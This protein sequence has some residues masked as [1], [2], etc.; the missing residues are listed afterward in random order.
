MEFKLR[1]HTLED[2]DQI[3]IYANNKGISDNMQDGFPYPYKKEDALGFI[4]MVMKNEPRNI[5]CIE[6]DGKPAGGIG[7]HPGQD[8]FRKN[9][10]LGYWLAEPYWGNGIIPKAIEEMTK[11][12]FNNFEVDRIFARP[13][14]RN[15]ASQRVLEKAG[16]TF[17]AKI[18]RSVYK[19]EVFEDEW[20]YG[21]WRA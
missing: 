8:I 14:G 19:N 11:Y 21:I 10:E 17:E 15:K 13:F 20:I 6:V 9:A 16:F 5:L 4:E 12:A 1:P 18:P 3:A 7:I 2:A